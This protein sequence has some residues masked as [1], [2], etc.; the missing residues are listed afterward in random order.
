MTKEAAISSRPGRG[1]T[2]I[3]ACVHDQEPI[4]G[5]EI[6]PLQLWHC[7]AQ[8]QAAGLVSMYTQEAYRRQGMARACME[9]AIELLQQDGI[10]LCVLFGI[11]DLYELFGFVVVMP[12]YGVALSSEAWREL[13]PEPHLQ[14][15]TANQQHAL[16][17]LYQEYAKRRIGA[18][19]R[20]PECQVQPRKPV[21][22]RIHGVVRVLADSSGNVQGYACHSE[23]GSA[24]FEVA[25]AFAI[26][27]EAYQAI[28]VY[29]LHEMRRQ[30]RFELTVAVPPDDP[31]ALFL[32]QYD[33]RFV[34]RTC[35]SGGGMVRILD[36]ASL[37]GA[38]GPVFRKRLIAVD[39]RA[40]PR[41]LGFVAEHHQGTITLDGVGPP[42]EITLPI[43]PMTQLLFG[44]HTL[45]EA[46][47]TEGRVSGLGT[48]LWDLLFPIT[49]PFMYLRDRF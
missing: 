8:I 40:V 23:P 6:L 32:K 39:R 21:P 43:A 12:W 3:E 33:A 5:L 16:V 41:T 27:D 11:P 46:L 10:P 48:E 30:G 25:E 36:L 29:L 4:S 42:V 18:M 1:T 22:W 15:P 49:H 2:L 38:L 17:S 9:R 47:R 34:V 13:P 19:V 20:D 26:K 31:F 35:R 45:S 14:A 37:C 28:L 7:G 44:Y 24:T